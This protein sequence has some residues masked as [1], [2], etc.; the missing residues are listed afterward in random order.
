MT[1]L[2]WGTSFYCQNAAAPFY[3][4]FTGDLDTS[5]AAYRLTGT[6]VLSGLF[7]RLLV[8]LVFI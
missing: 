4:R 7:D 6:V 1:S 2:S 3:K 8:D 5:L